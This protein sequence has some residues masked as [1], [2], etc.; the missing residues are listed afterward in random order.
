MLA[1]KLQEEKNKNRKKSK[2]NADLLTDERFKSLFENADFEIDINSEE[3]RSEL[4]I[5]Y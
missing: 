5:I 3:Y 2:G 1:K 4:L